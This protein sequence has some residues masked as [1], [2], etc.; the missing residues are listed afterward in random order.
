MQ[1]ILPG[2]FGSS[3]G[4]AIWLEL[5]LLWLQDVSHTIHQIENDVGAQSE[6]KGAIE[7]PLCFRT[8]RKEEKQEEKGNAS[9]PA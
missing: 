6:E 8:Y 3:C 7:I 5:F 9:R 1:Q 2:I 4:I